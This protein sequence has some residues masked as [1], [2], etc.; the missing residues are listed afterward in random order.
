MSLQLVVNSLILYVSLISYWLIYRSWRQGYDVR[1]TTPPA[2]PWNSRRGLSQM[3]RTRAEPD[4]LLEFETLLIGQDYSIHD[5]E[6]TESF[7]L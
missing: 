1:L 4:H 7:E 3:R 6:H 2:R 5:L